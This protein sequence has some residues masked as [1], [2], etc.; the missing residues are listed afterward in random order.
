MRLYSASIT[1]IQD[2][3]HK[4]TSLTPILYRIVQ[5][6]VAEM[7]GSCRSQV[8]KPLFHFED[9]CNSSNTVKRAKKIFSDLTYSSPK[10]DIT[11]YSK[12][13]CAAQRRT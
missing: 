13:R 8:F 4:C 11:R 5:C 12:Q 10:Y 6:K 3:S 7:S 9:Y 2:A 1:V